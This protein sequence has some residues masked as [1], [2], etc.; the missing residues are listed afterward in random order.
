MKATHIDVQM[1]NIN[2]VKHYRAGLHNSNDFKFE[3]D[4]L[5]TLDMFRNRIMNTIGTGIV[6]H[7]LA[8]WII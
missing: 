2:N 7:F 5:E 3:T 4:G 8:D 1:Y 6:T